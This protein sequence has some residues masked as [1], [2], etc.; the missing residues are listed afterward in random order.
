MFSLY[1]KQSAL[2]QQR[3]H[4]ANRSLGQ[5]EVASDVAAVHC[6]S[7]VGEGISQR[8]IRSRVL[9]QEGGDAFHCGLLRKREYHAL[10]RTDF[11][12][13]CRLHALSHVLVLHAVLSQVLC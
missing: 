7:Q 13:H 10:P 12:D 2:V 9:D 11:P 8:D 1:C 4:A 6:Q 3:K 5:S